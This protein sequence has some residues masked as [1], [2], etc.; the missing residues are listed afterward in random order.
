MR[1]EVGSV[2]GEWIKCR[3]DAAAGGWEVPAKEMGEAGAGRR[4]EGGRCLSG[5]QTTAQMRSEAFSSE[6]RPREPSVP[7]GRQEATVASLS[8]PP[9]GLLGDASI[10]RVYPA[11][12]VRP[13][14]ALVALEDAWAPGAGRG[15][16]GGANV[17]PS[18]LGRARGPSLGS[19]PACAVQLRDPARPRDARR[20]GPERRLPRV[21]PPLAGRTAWSHYRP[22]PC[23]RAPR[24]G[25]SLRPGE[26]RGI[27][28]PRPEIPPEGPG[29]A[30]GAR[31]PAEPGN[32]PAPPLPL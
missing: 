32:P 29:W 7:R 5:A 15:A 9:T 26:G 8:A 17:I 18:L 24:A 13:R 12:E 23:P 27:I 19:R 21:P 14:V 11:K 1:A 22:S 25:G 31:G 6:H 28:N 3:V 16:P 30:A 4:Q 2:C 10:L 20:G